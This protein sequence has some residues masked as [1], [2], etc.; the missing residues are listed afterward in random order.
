[1]EPNYDPDAQKASLKQEVYVAQRISEFLNDEIIA[2]TL[3]GMLHG[4]QNDWLVTQTAQEREALWIRVQGLQ[5]FLVTLRSLIDSGK[6]AAV[7][8]E[9]FTNDDEEQV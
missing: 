7:Q 3:N 6:M 2:K 8:L 4:L 5:E 1:L 9:S